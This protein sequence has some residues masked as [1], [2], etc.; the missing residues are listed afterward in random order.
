MLKNK[1]IVIGL[2]CLIDM[3]GVIWF[4]NEWSEQRNIDFY[5]KVKQKDDQI[6]TMLQTQEVGDYQ[7]VLY[8][9][10]DRI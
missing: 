5:K 2:L 8:E 4:L 10:K 9:K 7:F 6:Q 3:I 1:K